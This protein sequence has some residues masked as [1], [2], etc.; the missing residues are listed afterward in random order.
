V[1]EGEHGEQGNDTVS[2]PDILER[3]RA[4][5][6]L[7]DPSQEE[8]LASAKRLA[9]AR[10]AVRD[11]PDWRPA[12]TE[13]LAIAAIEQAHTYVLD[14]RA[15]KREGGVDLNKRLAKAQLA[16]MLVARRSGFGSYD[17]YRRACRPR[18]SFTSGALHR[19]RSYRELA[20]A[21]G[22]WQ[23]MREALAGEMVIDLT[24]DDARV[25]TT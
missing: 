11:L 21:E 7:D 13:R 22:E 9:A 17:E 25:A 1:S 4:L 8:V 24:G 5:L 20:S 14:A 3:T 10:M 19:L 2:I 18:T 16:E 23:R 6:A 12:R 15:A